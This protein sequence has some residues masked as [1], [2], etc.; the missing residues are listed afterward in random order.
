MGGEFFL[1]ILDEP[2]FKAITQDQWTGALTD[3]MMYVPDSYKGITWDHY[4]STGDIK[5]ESYGR[6]L[7]IPSKLPTKE[8]DI[9]LTFNGMA[10]P[11][12]AMQVLIHLCVLFPLAFK[13]ESGDGWNYAELAGALKRREFNKLPR[14]QF[15]LTERGMYTRDWSF[16]GVAFAPPPWMK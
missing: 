9:T 7:I 15:T 12:M 1:S 16:D 2:T 6:K 3:I 10:V 5:V 4:I 13:L 11:E 14:S 8:S